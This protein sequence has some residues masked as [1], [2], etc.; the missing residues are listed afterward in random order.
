M[1]TLRRLGVVMDPI[2]AISYAKDS[3]LAMLLAAQ[4]RGFALAYLEPARSAAARRRRV[5]AHA[6]AHGQAR[7]RRVVHPGGAAIEPL[8]ALECILMRKDPPFDTEY[9]YSTYILERAESQGVLVV[10]RPRGLRT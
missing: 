6:S 2:G 3:T 1:S 4:A 9:I 5:R 8:S 10:N 7:P